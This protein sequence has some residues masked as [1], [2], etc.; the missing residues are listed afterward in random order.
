MFGF[1]F[2]ILTFKVIYKNNC[3]Y[4]RR[5]QAIYVSSISVFSAVLSIFTFHEF[6]TIDGFLIPECQVNGV[7]DDITIISRD[8][9]TKHAVGLITYIMMFCNDR[10]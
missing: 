8:L 1:Y 10:L 6:G 7:Q 9:S 5:I 3:L 4:K 2:N